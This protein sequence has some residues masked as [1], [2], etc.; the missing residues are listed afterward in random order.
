MENTSYTVAPL[1][2]GTA[3]LLP[4]LDPRDTDRGLLE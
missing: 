1:D 3:W 4:A 2:L